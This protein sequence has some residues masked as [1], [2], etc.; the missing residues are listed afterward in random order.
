[1]QQM[2][3]RQKYSLG[4]FAVLTFIYFIVGFLTTVNGQ[5]QGM[6]PQTMQ[7]TLIR[8]LDVLQQAGINAIIQEKQRQL[9]AWLALNGK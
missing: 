9:D 4:P 3:A 5:F 2:I 8:Q 6:S 1:M 7:Q